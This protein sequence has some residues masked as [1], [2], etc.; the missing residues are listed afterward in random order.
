MLGYTQARELAL[1]NWP[2][3]TPYQGFH[4]LLLS[5]EVQQSQEKMGTELKLRNRYSPLL[6]RT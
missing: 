4:N 2:L 1:L 3:Q 5:E 6:P